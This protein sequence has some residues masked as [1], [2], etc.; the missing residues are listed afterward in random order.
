MLAE[1]DAKAQ[2]S[3]THTRCNLRTYASIRNVT[4]GTELLVV[5]FRRNI[6]EHLTS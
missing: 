6:D 1:L 2:D 5:I 3:V 4:F